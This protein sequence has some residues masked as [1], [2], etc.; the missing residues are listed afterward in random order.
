V[1][2]DR[3][4]HRQLIAFLA[5]WEIGRGRMRRSDL[6]VGEDRSVEFRG[7]AG[8]ALVEPQAGGQHAVVASPA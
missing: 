2:E 4:F 6:G 8:F 1:A 5:A 7:L 3:E